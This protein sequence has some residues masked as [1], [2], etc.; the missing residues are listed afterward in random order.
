LR[1]NK[2]VIDCGEVKKRGI[3]MHNAVKEAEV[4]DH[5]AI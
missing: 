4:P 2:K 1:N 5:V 3:I